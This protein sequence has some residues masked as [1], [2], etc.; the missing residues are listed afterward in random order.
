[1]GE[2][3]SPQLQFVDLQNNQISSVTLSSGYTNILM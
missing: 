2:N 3:I 1:M